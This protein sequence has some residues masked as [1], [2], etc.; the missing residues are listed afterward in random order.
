MPRWNLRRSETALASELELE[1][2]WESGLGLGLE[3]ER[4]SEKVMGSEKATDLAR[5]RAFARRPEW[6]APE[7]APA[8][9]P[10]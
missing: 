3:K 5:V 7:S 8:T 4:A 9:S 6:F 2:G 1:S 10:P